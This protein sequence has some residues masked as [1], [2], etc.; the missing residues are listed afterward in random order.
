MENVASS[1]GVFSNVVELLVQR[2]RSYDKDDRPL[3]IL[4]FGALASHPH[5]STDWRSMVRPLLEA[6]VTA[7][8]QG[9]VDDLYDELSHVVGYPDPNFPDIRKLLEQRATVEQLTD[10]IQRSRRLRAVAQEAVATKYRGHLESDEFEHPPHLGYELAAHWLRHGYVDHIISFNFDNLLD[11][12]IRNEFHD[13]GCEIIASEHDLSQSP[14]PNQ[15]KVI[16]IHGTVESP[17]TLRFSL[18]DTRTLDLTMRRYLDELVFP[19]ESKRQVNFVSFGY[20]WQDLNIATWLHSRER[21]IAKIFVFR[22]SS[23]IPELLRASPWPKV[24]DRNVPGKERETEET[25]PDLVEVASANDL[26]LSKS[27]PF[28]SVANT[29]SAIQEKVEKELN[30]LGIHYHSSG[31]HE[32]VGRIFG[33]RDNGNIKHTHLERLDLELFLHLFKCK[34]MLVVEN[35]AED[36]RV[37]RCY[38]IYRRSTKDIVDKGFYLDNGLWDGLLDYSKDVDLKDVYYAGGHFQEWVDRFYPRFSIDASYEVS[39]PTYLSEDERRSFVPTN[40]RY[41]EGEDLDSVRAGIYNMR[42]NAKAFFENRLKAVFDAAETE[43][44]AGMDNRDQWLFYEASPIRSHIELNE[45]TTRILRQDGTALLCVAESGDFISRHDANFKGR[46]LLL[47]SARYDISKWPVGKEK[48][49][50]VRDLGPTLEF[51][52]HWK[53]HNRH[54]TMAIDEEARKLGPAIYF[55]RSHKTTRVQ[56]VYITNTWDLIEVLLVFFLYVSRSIGPIQGKDPKDDTETLKRLGD[57]KD[58]ALERI[59]SQEGRE[60]RREDFR[61]RLNQAWLQVERWCNTPKSSGG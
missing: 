8:G 49:Q 14:N 37:Q 19:A 30:R 50:A 33:F 2:Y 45:I 12:A 54:L 46:D 17:D 47:V 52:L 4:V 42:V 24:P 25:L 34:G 9:I 15:P 61:S 56:P 55:R 59:N 1:A 53:V 6:A 13:E 44:V 11:V 35:I 36:K 23:K 21:R 28:K 3:V 26:F 60:K 32:V 58:L 7:N 10:A 27:R 20:S 16:K 38:E 31:R 40:D 39:K 57:I 18:N 51:G 43:V 22:G 5:I 48:H 29:I 41:I